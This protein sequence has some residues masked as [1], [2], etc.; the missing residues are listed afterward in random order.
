MVG[1]GPGA[2]I[3]G[4]TGAITS[5]LGSVGEARDLAISLDTLKRTLGDINVSFEDLQ[6]RTRGLADEFSLTDSEAIGLTRSY[7]T[8]ANADKNLPGLQNEVGVGVGFSRSFGLAPSA[9]VDFFGQMRGLGITKNADDNKRLALLIGES[10]A[11]AGELPRMADVMAGLSRY[12]E[13]TATRSLA[14]GDGSAWLSK[15]A[16]LSGSGL[17]GMTPGTTSNMIAKADA[18]VSQGGITE[19]GKN[20]M[21]GQLQKELGLNP[22]QANAQLEGGLFAT[23]KSTFGEGSA[24][25]SYYAKKGVKVPEAAKSTR[26]NMEILMGALER[27]YA[28]RPDLMLDAMKNQ[29]GLSSAQAAAW[30]SSGS[31]KLGGLVGR[32]G[33]LGIDPS[34]VNSTGISQLSQIEA[35]TKLTDA[36]KDAMVRDTATK[37]QEDTDGSIARKASIDG[38]NAMIRL[39]NEGLPM[40]SAIQAGVLKMAGIDPLGPEKEVLNAEHG[41]RLSAIDAKQGKER[42]E[43]LLDYQNATPW[44][45]RVTGLGLDDNQTQLKERYEAADAELIEARKAENSRYGSAQRN[46]G[47][48]AGATSGSLPNAV[49]GATPDLLKRAAQ[50]DALHGLPDGTTA[51][52]IM[53]ESSFDSG[54][55][56]RKGARGMFQIMPDNVASLSKRA[57]RQLDPT[58]TDDAFYMFNQLM[59]E[60]DRKYGNDTNKKLRSYHGGYDQSKWG[61]ENADYVP[62]IEKRKRELEAARSDQINVHVHQTGEFTLRDPGG[63]QVAVADIQTSIGS[64]Q[65]NGGQSR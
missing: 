38:G 52:L 15:S 29:F 59:G 19:A 40:I 48:S 20:F 2:V 13:S 8:M 36:Q 63:Q 24:M 44:A 51:A 47:T 3:G 37:N 7:A 22:I 43:A 4:V 21:V 10:V 57:G 25:A 32:L 41:K 65:V 5:L 1:G 60:R 30:Q 12:M 35:D 6:G 27:Q 39:A 16:A 11:K 23:G 42:D 33:R 50:S 45:K 49:S 18:A 34:K 17:P 9:G 14:A 58:N 28:G 54:A 26:T 31:V 46:L 56:S 53:Q 64:P 61:A 55:V 62:A